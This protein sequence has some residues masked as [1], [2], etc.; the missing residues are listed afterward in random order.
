MTLTIKRGDVFRYEMAGAGGWGDPLERDPARVL[1]DI[2]N[3][4]VTATLAREQYG[5]VVDTQTWHVDDEKTAELRRAM[6]V[7]RAWSKPPF[8]DRGELPTGARATKRAAIVIMDWRSTGVTAFRVGVDIGGTFTDI[9]FLNEQ[10]RLVTKKVSSSVGDYARAIVE[11][12]GQ[13]FDEQKLDHADVE[14][15]LHATTVASNAILE[16]KGARTGLITTKGFRDVLE[17]R[18]LAHAAALRSQVGEA[19]AARRSLSAAR[20]R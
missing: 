3:E 1:S 12:I 6:R 18:R 4:Y 14:E 7:R 16:H 9:V 20:G 8:V 19:A 10:G 15:V 2:R 11:G 17:L 13:V 5:V